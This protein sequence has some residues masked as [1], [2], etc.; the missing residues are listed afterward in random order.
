MIRQISFKPPFKKTNMRRSRLVVKSD[1]DKM[2]PDN[3]VTVK[4]NF[5]PSD[6]NFTD[7]S[8]NKAS[9]RISYK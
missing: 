4:L 9:A 6:S 5:A 2:Y 8:C 3:R 1:I 7:S